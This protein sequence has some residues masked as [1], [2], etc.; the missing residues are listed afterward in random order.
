M[1]ASDGLWDYM[2]PREV[3]NLLSSQENAQA[4]AHSLESIAVDEWQ[5]VVID[6]SEIEVEYRRH[7]FHSH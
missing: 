2:S 4:I 3:G 7:F 5:K 6:S 1:V